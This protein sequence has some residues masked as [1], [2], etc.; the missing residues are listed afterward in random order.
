[1]GTGEKASG[2][3]ADQETVACFMAQF[4][5]SLVQSGVSE[6]CISP[7]SRS[8][9]LAVSAFRTPNLN[10]RAIL[11]E[12][13]AA[14]FALGLARQSQAPVALICTS[15]SAVANYLPA[16]IEAHHA[17]IPLLVFSADRPPELRDWGAG[18][19]IDQVGLYGTAVRLFVDV[20][21][22]VSGP[23]GLRYAS[24]LAS[25]A[26]ADATCGP[27]GP[28]H[29]NFPLR[30][31][32]EPPEGFFWKGQGESGSNSI[33][34]AAQSKPLRVPASA[35]LNSL[36]SRL[37][38]FER[39]VISCGPLVDDP[40]LRA[41]IGR[42]A[43]EMK[44]PIVADPT[45]QQRRGAHVETAPVLA[46][47]DLWLRDESVVEAFRP[48]VV[49]RL[50]DSPVSKSLRKALLKNPP[51]DF[52]LVDPDGVFHDPDHLATEVVRADP[53]SVCEAWLLELD[54]AALKRS[55]SAYCETWE[56][57]DRA[58]ARELKVWA[59]SSS[60]FL[61]PQTVM[62]LSEALNSEV[63]LFV[64]NSMP[65]RDLDAFL[66]QDSKSLRVL[67]QR[68]ASGIDG[69]V[70]GAAGAS[71]AGEGAVVLFTGDLALLHDAGGMLTAR[72]HAE[73][74][75]IVVIQNDG[76][77]IFSFLPI[78]DQGDSVG[79]EEFFR[80]PHGLKLEDLARFY[81]A[82]F[83]RAEQAQ[84]LASA[85]A[86]TVGAPGVHLIEVPVDR[87]ENLKCFREAVSLACTV[88]RDTLN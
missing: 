76:G 62:V 31:P 1:M 37:S 85:L 16:V 86:Q 87:D 71:A 51:T 78:S 64:S 49:L 77:G 70:S 33:G 42:L 19:T 59:D 28:V 55:D 72:D 52:V 73:S 11:D 35:H 80:T 68:G 54:T 82:H 25:R 30:E 32:L 56:A 46:H 4:F 24:A 26:V 39:G 40:K 6:V 69:I 20:P 38:R 66:F 43:T 8:T 2:F 18:Q 22:P 17:R 75:T 12:R 60:R 67:S 13:S 50:G 61:E 79:F 63:T 47:S 15:G 5:E 84:T 44:W 48:D 27:A 36:V 21:P 45:S 23:A 29:L 34:T 14:F 65:V 3:R 10:S 57:L 41:A 88:A 83:Y 58:V 7:G 74:L 9:P 53:L 81:G